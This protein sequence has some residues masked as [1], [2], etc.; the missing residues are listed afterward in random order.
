MKIKFSKL[1]C[2]T[3]A[4]KGVSLFYSLRLSQVKAVWRFLGQW[5]LLSG[6]VDIS[7]GSEWSLGSFFPWEG[8][9]QREW[10]LVRV[11]QVDHYCRAPHAQQAWLHF[12]IHVL[13][14]CTTRIVSSPGNSQGS[15][16]ILPWCDPVL[17]HVSV[18]R[19]SNETISIWTSAYSVCMHVCVGEW[20]DSKM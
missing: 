14:P 2:L 10:L 18:L 5:R 8:Q 3:S 11:F 15:S 4:F 12:S 13:L 17:R 6:S 9:I 7:G 1:Y 16:F 20:G 19:F